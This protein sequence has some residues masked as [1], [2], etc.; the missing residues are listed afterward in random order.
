MAAA[1]GSV[2]VRGRRGVCGGG[3]WRSE[4]WGWEERE[5]DDGLVETG[6]RGQRRMVMTDERERKVGLGLVDR[7]IAILSKAIAG[8]YPNLAGDDDSNQWRLINGQLADKHSYHHCHFLFTSRRIEVGVNAC[9]VVG[10][11][12]GKR[13][14]CT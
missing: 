2:H 6:E 12:R 4:V 1:A 13:R 5:R 7:V 14:A 8:A 11:Q 10:F 9:M 3:E